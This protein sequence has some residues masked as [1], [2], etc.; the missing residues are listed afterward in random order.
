MTEKKIC[1]LLSIASAALGL[2][3]AP[4]MCAGENCAFSTRVYNGM[5]YLYSCAL[6]DMAD[7]LGTIAGNS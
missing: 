1:P 6:K 5:E 2:N 3:T 4:A 7:S